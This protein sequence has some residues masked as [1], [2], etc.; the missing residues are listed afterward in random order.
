[1]LG[2]SGHQLCPPALSAGAQLRVGRSWQNL[3]LY[4]PGDMYLMPSGRETGGSPVTVSPLK[5]EMHDMSRQ[6]EAEVTSSSCWFRSKC[7]I[8]GRLTNS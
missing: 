6:E 5:G 4:G 2:Q 8:Y 7:Q 1:M 3:L